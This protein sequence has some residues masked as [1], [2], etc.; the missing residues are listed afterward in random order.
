MIE[1]T[2]GRCG[3]I[4]GSFAG[5]T[6]NNGTAPLVFEIGHVAPEA[7]TSL[8]QDKTLSTNELTSGSRRSSNGQKSAAG[9]NRK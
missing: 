8:L 1:N 7:W 2:A 9:T 3:T 6:Q 5:G 4:S